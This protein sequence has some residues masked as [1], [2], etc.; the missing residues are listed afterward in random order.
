MIGFYLH[1]NCNHS[2][3]SYKL[4]MIHQYV[5]MVHCNLANIETHSF[6]HI[7]QL[8]MLWTTRNT[9]N[10]EIMWCVKWHFIFKWC[11]KLPTEVTVCSNKTVLASV[12][13]RPIYIVTWF[14]VYTVTTAEFFTRH[15]KVTGS[16][17]WFQL[18]TYHQQRVLHVTT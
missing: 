14:I 11:C 8:R 3:L 15:P 9:Y 1:C 17:I 13:T 4:Y 5:H 7:Y 16:T 10:K 12:R 18:N 6:C 2:S